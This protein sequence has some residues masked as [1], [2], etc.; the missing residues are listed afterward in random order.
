MAMEQM[1]Q[2]LIGDTRYGV[3]GAINHINN[4][5]EQALR[6]APSGIQLH[7]YQDDLGEAPFYEDP[8]K[9]ELIYEDPW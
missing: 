9:E 6:V 1:Q 3:L 8:G 7:P 2:S 5:I 4:Q